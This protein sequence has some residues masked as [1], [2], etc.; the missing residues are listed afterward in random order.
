VV[1]C[2]VVTAMTHEAR[3]SYRSTTLRPRGLGLVAEAVRELWDRRRLV[4]YLVRADIKKK[5]ADTL[6]GNLWWLIDPLLQMIVYL[7]LVEIIFARSTPDYP[8]FVFAAI[9]PWKWF[10]TSIN[11]SIVAVTS[12]DRLIKQLAFPKLVLPSAAVGAGLVNYAF[13]QI[14]LAALLIIGFPQRIS[15]FLVWIPVIAFVQLLFTLPL[16]FIVSAVNVFFR[17]IANLSR[18]V[19]RLWFYLSPALYG[20]ATV[21]KLG[22]SHPTFAAILRLNPFYVLFNAYRDV[23]YGPEA[24]TV[25]NSGGPTSPE[26]S[27]LLVLAAVSIGLLVVATWFFKRLEPAFA[28]VL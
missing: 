23:I 4:A 9:L 15:V 16:A 28:K 19:L 3:A 18:H 2:S 11:D 8:L 21:A 6:L 27:G 25:G 13:G 26:L 22:D 20:A 10:M 24:G 7:I 1:P 14:V 5:G 17:D 12:Q